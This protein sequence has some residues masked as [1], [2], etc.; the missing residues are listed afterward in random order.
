MAMEGI[1]H[2]PLAIDALVKT[3]RIALVICKQWFP[4]RWSI[5]VATTQRIRKLQVVQ[6]GCLKI[7]CRQRDVA[8]LTL[9]ANQW[10][11]ASRISPSPGI[12]EPQMR[13][14]MQL[15]SLWPTIESFDANTNIF[16]PS[17][18]IFDE[19]VE[20]AVIVK[21]SRLQQLVLGRANLPPAPAVFLYQLR[22]RKLLL[23]IFVEHPH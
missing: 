22:V 4:V 15:R 12:A 5:E 6:R 23:R 18:R 8:T 2:M 3:L 7:I 10:L 17:L 14:Q 11:T 21:D 19:D 1:F 13:Q 16:R 9:K 20:V